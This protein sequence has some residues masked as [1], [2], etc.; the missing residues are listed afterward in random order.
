MSDRHS[1]S[2]P[3]RVLANDD[4]LRLALEVAQLGFWDHDLVTH[5]IARSPEWGRMLGYEPQDVETTPEF[6]L[7]HVHPEDRPA[8]DLEIA[9]HEAGEKQAFRIEHRMRTKTGEWKWILNW[10]RV[11]ERDADGRALRAVGF[12]LDITD[13]KQAEAALARAD[14]LSTIGSLAGGIAHDFNNLLTVI[15]GGLALARE[16]E[17]PEERKALLTDA[18]RA[19]RRSQELTERLLTFARGGRPLMTPLDLDRAVVAAHDLVMSGSVCRVRFESEPDLPQVNGN[20][21]QLVQVFQNLLL[22]AAQA[23]PEGG[24]ITVACRRHT[25]LNALGSVLPAGDY[26]EATVRDEGPGIPN[27][28]AGRIFDPFFTTRT[29][30]KGLGLATAHSIVSEHGGLL[31]LVPDI[32]PGATMRVLLPVAATQDS[33]AGPTARTR[34]RERARRILVMDDEDLVRR[35]VMTCVERL[36]FTADGA[37]DGAE[38]VE[39]YEAA[40]RNGAPYEAVI[41]D[42][43]IPGGMG[44]KEA[45]SRILTTDPRARVI[46]SSGYSDDPVMANYREHGFRGRL[47]KPYEPMDL[48]NV[49]E[50]LLARDT[51]TEG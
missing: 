33:A 32:G 22:N 2:P 37:S 10:G 15:G 23:M 27:A 29:E 51:R 14:K 5:E 20:E 3:S 45:V 6:W 43:T 39:R 16:S 42:L 50:T 12:H 8:V 28:L 44:G 31:E 34:E 41:M 47:A 26:V 48:R 25:L 9:R 7:D 35:I 46:V 11:V 13:R 21:G 40:H 36:G 1:P 38:A 17:D 18:L 19:T 24:T 4:T 30:G 49:L